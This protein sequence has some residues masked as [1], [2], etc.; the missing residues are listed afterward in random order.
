[1]TNKEFEHI[2]REYFKVLCHVA[3]PVV[4]D[5]DVAK[6]I[7]QQVFLKLW[8]NREKYQI[9]T[10]VRS[11]LHRAVVNTALNHVESDKKSRK[12]SLSPLVESVAE[13]EISDETDNEKL[14]I[15]IEE[16]IKA[17]PPQCQTVFSL[18]RYSEMSNKEIA[19]YLNIS[20]KAVEK[21]ITKAMKVLKVSL[22]GV[23][24]LVLLILV[25]HIIKNIVFNNQRITN[26]SVHFTD[27]GSQTTAH[28]SW[29]TVYGSCF[30]SA[31]QPRSTKNNYSGRV[32]ALEHCHTKN[33]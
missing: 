14:K 10:S 12:L 33:A 25:M 21:H 26:S 32:F 18:S 31:L 5:P 1:M 19:E 15:K 3:Y 29:L 23:Y 24:L 30:D 20:I 2:F 22:K 13:P 4:K 6:D 17:L 7:V 8:N 16:A 11:Y 9:Q 27:N 28:G